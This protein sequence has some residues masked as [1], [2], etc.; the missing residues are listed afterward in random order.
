MAATGNKSPGWVRVFGA[1]LLLAGLALL[2]LSW[3]LLGQQ[4]QFRAGAVPTTGVVESLVRHSY[5]S[6]TDVRTSTYPSNTTSSTAPM[7]RYYDAQGHDYLFTA[8]EV[9]TQ[10]ASFRVGER[11]QVY[12]D[13]A[14]PWRA[15]VAAPVL[16]HMPSLVTGIMGVVVGGLGLMC[17]LVLGGGGSAGGSAAG[18]WVSR[19][20]TSS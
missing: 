12:Y 5:Q 10:P 8:S 20:W 7:I 18:R 14:R 4:Q 3:H 13:P 9:A 19:T 2:A 11:V 1:A 15:Q 16:S 17:L 6:N